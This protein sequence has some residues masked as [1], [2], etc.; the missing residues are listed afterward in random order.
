MAAYCLFSM[1]LIPYVSLF[2]TET[3][4]SFSLNKK[5]Q[6]QKGFTNIKLFHKNR[7]AAV[8]FTLKS[9]TTSLLKKGWHD[10]LMLVF[11]DSEILKETLVLI[12]LITNG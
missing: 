8:Q 3:T 9:S 1:Q 6:S 2:L 12:Q 10:P 5:F 4:Y 7:S 11:T